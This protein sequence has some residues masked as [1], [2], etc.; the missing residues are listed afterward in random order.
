[1]LFLFHVSAF[2]WGNLK[3][4]IQFKP[5]SDQSRRFCL[6]HSNHLGIYHIV[7]AQGL[8]ML[9]ENKQRRWGCSLEE[10][11]R[12][13]FCDFKHWCSRNKIRCSQ[14]RW[15]LKKLNMTDSNGMPSFPSLD[16][17]AFNSRVIL[18]FLADPSHRF[19]AGLF[20]P[21]NDKMIV[22]KFWIASQKIEGWQPV[23]YCLDFPNWKGHLQKPYA[24]DELSSNLD[25]LLSQLPG[26]SH[27]AFKQRKQLWTL[28]VATVWLATVKLWNLRWY[29]HPLGLTSK[30]MQCIIVGRLGCL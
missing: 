25:E 10:A 3:F 18:A 23:K 13:C 8:I 4:C 17:K 16:A 14:R 1:M 21:H 11:I 29:F 6:M 26:E 12:H 20:T 24:Q 27:Q 5:C 28:G 9:A 7:N 2:F 19:W 30:P 22:Y 15:S